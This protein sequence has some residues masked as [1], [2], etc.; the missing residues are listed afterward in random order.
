MKKLLYYLSVVTL[1][2]GVGLLVYLFYLLFYPFTPLV[3]HSFIVTSKTVKPGEPIYYK[4]DFCRNTDIASIAYRSLVS[5]SNRGYTIALPIVSGNTK[6][7]C[8]VSTNFLQI[9]LG[10]PLGTYYLQG[11]T[12]FPVNYFRTIRV[13]YKTNV[14]E[15]VK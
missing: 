7:G 10:T 6:V 14:F 5:T 4:V 13:H 15:V 8:R 1:L 11:D 12:T 9:P 3:V 2:A